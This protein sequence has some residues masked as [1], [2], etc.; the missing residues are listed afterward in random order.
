KPLSETETHAERSIARSIILLIFL[1]AEYGI[2]D[3]SVTGVQTCALPICSPPPPPSSWSRRRASTSTRS[4][5]GAGAAA[6]PEAALARGEIGRASGRE[7]DAIAIEDG[8]TR[9]RK[10]QGNIFACSTR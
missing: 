2:R 7:R 10:M 4:S 8:L 3:S 6:L 1:Q 9:S 5:A